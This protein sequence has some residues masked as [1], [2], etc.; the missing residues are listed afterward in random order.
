VVGVC[1]T[2]TPPPPA[3]TR[4]L[5]NRALAAVGLV[6]Y[7]P[8]WWHWSYGDRFWACATQASHARYGPLPP[9]P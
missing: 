8:H 4:D 2:P 5:L 1:T 9:T 3:A 7:P 6:N